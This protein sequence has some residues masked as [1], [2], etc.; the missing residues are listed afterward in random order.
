MPLAVGTAIEILS[1][2]LIRASEVTIVATHPTD[3]GVMSF[4]A[5]ET[6]LNGA[7]LETLVH[8]DVAGDLHVESERQIERRGLSEWD[9]LYVFYPHKTLTNLVRGMKV[10]DSTNTYR[11]EYYHD[12]SDMQEIYLRK[13]SQP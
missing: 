9:T 8:E 7:T 11:L 2:G 1:F 6:T 3:A 13:L 4:Y 5:V 12:Y 10:L